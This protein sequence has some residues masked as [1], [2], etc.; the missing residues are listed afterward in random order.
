VGPVL[1]GAT[2]PL[3]GRKPAGGESAHLRPEIRAIFL[4]ERFALLEASG[5]MTG[6]LRSVPQLDGAAELCRHLPSIGGLAPIWYQKAVCPGDHRFAIANAPLIAALTSLHGVKLSRLQLL[7][8]RGIRDR[9]PDWFDDSYNFCYL[10]ALGVIEGERI[11]RQLED[12]RVVL[13]VSH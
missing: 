1:R 8:L 3:L 11:T 12:S 13:S 6:E 7:Q 9:A 10:F 2:N 4:K 5:V